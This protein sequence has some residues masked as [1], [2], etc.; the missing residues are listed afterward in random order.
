MKKT[1]AHADRIIL[2]LIGGLLAAVYEFASR[3]VYNEG[4]GMWHGLNF[5]LAVYVGSLF[6]AFLLFLILTALLDFLRGKIGGNWTLSLFPRILLYI[7]YT[8]AAA[9][10]FVLIYEIYINECNLYPGTTAS[11][12]LRQEVPHI[13]YF[14]VVIACAGALLISIPRLIEGTAVNIRLRL[15]SAVI[16]A[17]LNGIALYCPNIFNDRGGG[18]PHIHAVTNSIINV[19]KLQPYDVHNVSIYGHFGLICFPFVKLL[20]SDLYGVMQT[21]AVLGFITYLAAFYAAH[22]L[23]RHDVLYLLVLAGITGTTTVLTRRGQYF[24]INP[25]RLLFPALMLAVIAFGTYHDTK[26]ARVIAAVLEIIT[27]LCSVIWN[28]E[29]G[30]F[31]VAVCMCVIVLRALYRHPLFS[32]GMF[33]AV[34][35]A[36][37]YGI[38]CTL[39]AWGAVN[40][41]NIA[42]GGGINSFRLFVYPL[43]S[44]VYNVNHLRA[45]LPS[46]VYLYFFQILLFFLTVLRVLRRQHL[47][48]AVSES[49]E[50]MRF[51]ISLSGLSSLIYFMNRAAYG[52]IAISHI[53]MCLL[54]GSYAEYALT[55]SRSSLRKTLGEPSS[56]LTALFSALFFGCTVWLAAEGAMY[57]VVSLDYRATSS[58]ITAPMN[59]GIEKIRATV[60]E[61]TFAFGFCIPE[62]YYQLGWDNALTMIDWSDIN[63][64]NEA[65]AMEQ[66]AGHDSVLISG[67]DFENPDYRKVSTVTI[68]PYDFILY[69]RIPASEKKDAASGQEKKPAGA[70]AGGASASS[71]A[72][73]AAEAPKKP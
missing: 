70:A 34:F 32:K 60:P 31:C 59:E 3:S 52:N 72:S 33:A 64:L 20:G 4:E 16:L 42:C 10:V 47:G 62:V 23:I 61:N 44:G 51:A 15:F 46:I 58:W 48:T 73:S 36:L 26:R 14:A 2:L 63:D 45:E 53:Q 38:F 1:Y 65:Y 67:V 22:K 30:L 6:G 54:L 50:T 18:V 35:I 19:A 40:L 12:Y 8:A 39:G 13:L 28:F 49:A 41:Y 25:L 9:A 69:E 57:L 66:A 43:F 7:V 29:T 11:T 55:V 5:N 37:L 56:F 17:A 68:D 71:S 21:L 27:G 24:Q